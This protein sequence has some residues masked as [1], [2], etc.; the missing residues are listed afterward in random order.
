MKNKILTLVLSTLSF[1]A[2]A[3]SDCTNDVTNP[4]IMDFQPEITVSCDH[5]LS[6]IQPIVQDN[7]D[8]SVEVVFLE[9]IFQSGIPNV[10][11]V[12]R[13]YRAFD[14]A[15]NG[16]MESQIIHVV[17][18]TPP[19]I[20]PMGTTVIAC[21]DFPVFSQP[22]AIDNC[23]WSFLMFQDNVDGSNPCQ[24]VYTRIWTAYDESG[25]TSSATETIISVDTIPPAIYGE[26]Y[27]EIPDSVSLD[28]LFATASEGCS[29]PIF[30]TYV[31]TEVSG[32]SYI[33]VYTATDGCG[34]TSTFQQIIHVFFVETDPEGDTDEEDDSDD[35]DEDGDDDSDDD[36]E[37]DDEEHCDETDDESKRVAICH[38][39]GNGNFITIYV[40][41]PAVQAHL[42]HGDNL[43]PCNTTINWHNQSLPMQMQLEHTR[44]G[45]IK[46][47]V[48][49]K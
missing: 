35:E 3:Q 22:T 5:D 34:N 33:R 44:D 40:A 24:T 12:Y 47:T 19:A 16:I 7:C 13:I 21:G 18:E 38:Q 26:V 46:K 25:N 41:Q 37:E 49:Q 10:Y 48:R 8:D 29:S 1:F 20:S 42:N 36:D 14:N 45:K 2:I 4:Y 30:F 11:D 28:S 31:D 43:G 15:G 9:E 27:V 6:A 32:N 23:G 17:D 39:L